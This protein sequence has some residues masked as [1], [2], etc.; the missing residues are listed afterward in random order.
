MYL[1]TLKITILKCETCFEHNSLIIAHFFASPSKMIT[2]DLPIMLTCE[3][4]HFSSYDRIAI[5]KIW[6]KC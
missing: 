5:L 6:L 2:D 3:L 4:I 1:L